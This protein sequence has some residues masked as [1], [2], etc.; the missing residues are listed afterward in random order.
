MKIN[1]KDFKTVWMEDGKV[2]IIDQT[3]LPHKFEIREYENFNDVANAIKTMVVRGAP[4]IGATG[5]Y[6]L[7]LAALSFKGDD[8]EDFLRYIK[9]AKKLLA[10]TRPTAYDLFHGLDYVESCALKSENIADWK[11]KAEIGARE[12]AN[13]SAENCRRIG[14]F[15]N[16]IIR[17]GMNILTHCNAG[18]LACVDF[19]TALAPIRIAYLSGKKI[20]VFVDETRPRMQGSLLT[21]FELAEEG[22]P[23]AII[24][25]NAAG[26]FMAK[27]EVDVVIVG[28]DRIARNGDVA[29]KIGTYEKAVLAKE[30][31]I[32]F[33][34]AAP[35]ST[36][37]RNCA[38]GEEIPIEERDENEVLSLN[39]V[40]ISP[41]KSRARNPAFD[42]TPSKLITGII[43]EKGIVKPSEVN[44][45]LKF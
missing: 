20:F 13:R 16:S 44:L 19:G 1:W 40:R 14:E 4:A 21:A 45:L 3:I 43:T 12:Y 34:V 32:P 11:R 38:S 7:A 26:F 31:N 39:G 5:A 8:F 30:N 37:D 35:T 28:A 10:E 22:I 15:G 23:H 2:K 29:N 42:V 33:Y 6:G 27:R 24:P 18:A 41:V 36:F 9:S 25:D 17:D